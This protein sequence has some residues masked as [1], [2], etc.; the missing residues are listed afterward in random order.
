MRNSLP[1]ERAIVRIGGHCS[2]S[3]RGPEGRR[4]DYLHEA[5]DVNINIFIQNGDLT[6]VNKFIQRLKSCHIILGI[7]DGRGDYLLS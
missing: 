5:D 4:S 1:G 7:Q 6:L 3:S 2:R